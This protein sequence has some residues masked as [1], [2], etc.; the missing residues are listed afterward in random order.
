M[1]PI[2]IFNKVFPSF[3]KADLNVEGA[4]KQVNK[5]QGDMT[6][7]ESRHFTNSDKLKGDVSVLI[8]LKWASTTLAV[9]DKGKTN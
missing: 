5:K 8:L 3:A 2:V 7:I 1:K 6:S 4:F 9:K